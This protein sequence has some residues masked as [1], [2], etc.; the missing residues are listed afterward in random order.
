MQGQ[1]YTFGIIGLSGTCA[2]L[3]GQEVCCEM[4]RVVFLPLLLPFFTFPFFKLHNFFHHLDRIHIPVLALHFYLTNIVMLQFP[5]PGRIVM[6]ILSQCH[7]VTFN[8]LTYPGEDLDILDPVERVLVTVCVL[9]VKVIQSRLGSLLGL[10]GVAHD[11]PNVHL[12]P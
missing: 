10:R 7:R 9:A 6:S 2:N 4:T 11:S 5:G 8:L 1:T 12:S 3:T